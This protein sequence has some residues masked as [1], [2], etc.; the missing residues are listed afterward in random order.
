MPRWHRVSMTFVLSKLVKNPIFF[1]RTTEITITWSSFP[2]LGVGVCEQSG[3]RVTIER[4]LKRIDVKALVVPIEFFLFERTLKRAPLRVIRG[5]Y[6]IGSVILLEAFRDEHNGLD[7]FWVL[8]THLTW[9]P[10]DTVIALTMKLSPSSSCCS[11]PF[12]ST[13]RHA[14][15]PDLTG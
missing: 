11:V 3:V 5:D 12:I 2:I 15:V 13:K 7:L 1:D 6:P 9:F 10:F 14:V 4:T 8:M